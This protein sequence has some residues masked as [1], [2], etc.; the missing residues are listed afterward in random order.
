M[1]KE[2]HPSLK[3][4]PDL[5]SL[6][7]ALHTRFI[8]LGGSPKRPRNYDQKIL[9]AGYDTEER[10]QRLD[11]AKLEA[12]GVAPGHIRDAMD[13]LFIN[14]NVGSQ[15]TAPMQGQRD[16]NI[17]KAGNLAKAGNNAAK[18][19]FPV[20]IMGL[21]GAALTGDRNPVVVTEGI[22]KLIADEIIPEEI[23]QVIES[24]SQ[25]VHSYTIGQIQRKLRAVKSA[26]TAQLT[27]NSHD[28][29][30]KRSPQWF[31]L[32]VPAEKRLKSILFELVQGE[33]EIHLAAAKIQALQRSAKAKERVQRIRLEHAIWTAVKG[34]D[35]EQVGS[36]IDESAALLELRHPELENTLL[37]EAASAGHTETVQLLIAAKIDVEALTNCGGTALYWGAMNGH[38]DACNAL[39][40]GG[41]DKS[42]KTQF[43]YLPYDVAKSKGHEKLA[44]LLRAK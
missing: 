37:H 7:A 27:Y 15:Q 36:L 14:T 39:L 19:G 42:I 24:L 8:S 5:E 26:Q 2:L 31:Q 11:P 28:P 38:Y 29:A 35:T 41:A 44:K 30:T 6:E 12:I 23:V 22:R 20:F 33:Q 4:L 9:D 21:Q 16:S 25:P 43:K 18:A 40:I 3:G 1:V 32:L 13:N 17:A 10:L 34:G